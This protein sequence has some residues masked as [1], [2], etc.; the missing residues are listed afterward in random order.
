MSLNNILRSKYPN[1]I[2]NIN[3]KIIFFDLDCVISKISHTDITIASHVNYLSQSILSIFVFLE[4]EGFNINFITAN[5]VYSTESNRRALKHLI[6]Q[7]SGVTINQ[8]IRE[9][10]DKGLKM[11]SLFPHVDSSDILFFDDTMKNI[12]T[13]STY[14]IICIHVARDIFNSFTVGSGNCS[15]LTI[16]RVITGLSI[17]FN[18]N[19]FKLSRSF[20]GLPSSSH[21]KNIDNINNIDWNAAGTLPSSSHTKNID[22]IN[23]IDWNAAGTLPYIY[24]ND[25][26]LF[27]FG[28]D[29][30]FNKSAP[31]YADFGGSRDKSNNSVGHNYL[32]ALKYYQSLPISQTKQ[33]QILYNTLHHMS[34]LMKYD[35]EINYGSSSLASQYYFTNDIGFQTK[36][37][38]KA[39][40][41]SKYTAVREMVEEISNVNGSQVFKD[42]LM[43]DTIDSLFHKMNYYLCTFINYNKT[44]L[45]DMYMVELKDIPTNQIEGPMFNNEKTF[46]RFMDLNCLKKLIMDESSCAINTGCEQ[47]Q[48]PSQYYNNTTDGCSE[49]CLRPP[50]R[51]MI[52]NNMVIFEYLEINKH[53]EKIISNHIEYKKDT[54]SCYLTN[55]NPDDYQNKEVCSLTSNKLI[56]C[57]PV[58]KITDLQKKILFLCKLT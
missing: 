12:R 20:S 34:P 44:F 6:L 52:K 15:S 50:T 49:Y 5:S 28:L 16:S 31:G 17:Y 23:N 56:N 19:S 42:S 2:R 43:K 53:V 29:C 48:P 22:N 46:Y 51:K 18:K 8:I 57:K 10:H 25:K 47:N 1:Q 14:G 26:L 35:N 36:E 4:K 38:Y 41:S 30:F 33:Y 37:T 9:S 40:Y 32:S 11:I 54:L 24:H 3:Q 45:Y 13:A 7:K 27:L 21:T 55:D 58:N 39:D